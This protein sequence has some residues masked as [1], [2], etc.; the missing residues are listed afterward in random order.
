MNFAKLIR[1]LC[2]QEPGNRQLLWAWFAI[3]LVVVIADLLTKKMVSDSLGMYERINVFPMFDIT[4]RH[5]YGAAFSFL[6]GAGGWQV[7][8]FGLVAGAVSIAIAIWI[9]KI[10][11]RKSL[12]VFGLS[13][14]LGGAVGNLYDRVTLGY[15][16]DFLLVYYEQHQFPAFNVADAAITAG[17]GVLLLDAFLGAK[18]I[19][20]RGT[21]SKTNE[22]EVK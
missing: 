10:G 21:D 6:A 18:N 14:I 22:V 7:W 3:S 17:A 13:L 11:T 1:G 2:Q 8:F 20:T 16:V 19:K 5:N 4:L 12:E 15:V 9:M